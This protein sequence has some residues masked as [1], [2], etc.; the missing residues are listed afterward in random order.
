MNDPCGSLLRFELRSSTVAHSVSICTRKAPRARGE[1]KQRIN[2]LD[3]WREA[4]FWT[5]LERAALEW[6]KAVM[7]TAGGQVPE[8]VSERAR[9]QFSEQELVNLTLAVIAIN[10]G[11]R[12]LIYEFSGCSRC[13]PVESVRVDR[14]VEMMGARTFLVCSDRLIPSGPGRNLTTERLTEAVRSASDTVIAMSKCNDSFNSAVKLVSENVDC[15][16][17]LGGQTGVMVGSHART[18]G[19]DHGLGV[20]TQHLRARQREHRSQSRFHHPGA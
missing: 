4:A 1:S 13:L 9:R 20:C 12:L 2:L 3:S 8:D 11:N 17:R 6:T 7:L 10:G 16:D 15:P 5:E 19:S 18:D 14:F